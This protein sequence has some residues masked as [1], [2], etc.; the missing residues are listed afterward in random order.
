MRHLWW[1]KCCPTADETVKTLGG[2]NRGPA[3][4]S[5][6]LRS[7]A[8][9]RLGA[10]MVLMAPEAQILSFE[11]FKL[12]YE[13]T[14]KVT[15]RRLET[16]RWNYSICVAILVG[17]AAI[18]KWGVISAE[19]RWIGVGAV[20]LLCVMAI[21]FCQLWLAQIRDFK[22]LNDAKFDILNRMAPLLAFD[23]ADPNRIRSYQPF[24]L[25]WDRLKHEGAVDR[26]RKLNV[27]ALKSSHMEQFIPRAFQMVFVAAVSAL[28][29]V[30]F[31]TPG[32]P[33]RPSETA[34]QTQKAP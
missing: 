32:L 14:E 5:R 29:V 28:I 27:L 4:I 8:N 12:Y 11:E 23:P 20:L 13:S 24:A 17:V 16:N 33:T 21:L 31:T 9:A 18:V 6:N 7:W 22:R 26:V 10:R 25:E 19:L 15:D 34:A 2:A 30:I 1:D 3:R